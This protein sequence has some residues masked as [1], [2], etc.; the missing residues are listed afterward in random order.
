[1][2]DEAKKPPLFDTFGYRKD[3]PKPVYKTYGLLRVKEGMWTVIEC[4]HRGGITLE[5]KALITPT[6]KLQAVETYKVALA[7]YIAS[8]FD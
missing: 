6:T 3:E 4:T 8:A 1:M 7:R 5:F 2:S